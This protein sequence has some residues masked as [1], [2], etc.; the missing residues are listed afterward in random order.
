MALGG[1]CAVYR[2]VIGNHQFSLEAVCLVG[3]HFRY[4]PE[5]GG[6]APRLS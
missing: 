6:G 3:W 2:G 5:L 4:L 1:G